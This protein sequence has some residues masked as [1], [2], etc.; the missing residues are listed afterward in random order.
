MNWKILSI[1]AIAII[2]G[3][4]WYIKNADKLDPVETAAQPPI[5]LPAQA[6]SI[7]RVEPIPS[8]TGAE[9]LIVSTPSNLNDSDQSVKA[10]VSNFAPPLLQWLMPDDQIRKW[11]ML[12]DQIANGELPKDYLPLNYSM[13]PFKATQDGEKWTADSSNYA[14]ANTLIDIVAAIPPSRLAPYYRAWYP[15]LDKAYR[16]LGR[17]DGFDKR[18]RTAIDCV[19]AVKSLTIQPKLIRPGVYYQYADPQF[20]S[21]STVE[22]L[23]WRLGPD[24]TERLQEFLRRLRLVL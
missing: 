18:L 11:V 9:S 8:P 2:A 19:L 16:E 21:A 14:R 20:E 4:A 10:A 12:I 3:A 13:V 7:E 23:M 5:R 6:G 17:S 24:N 15:L 22:K 1:A